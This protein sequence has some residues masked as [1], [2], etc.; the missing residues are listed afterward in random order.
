MLNNLINQIFL[1]GYSLNVFGT[2]FDALSSKYAIITYVV[3]ILVI[4]I[5]LVIFIYRLLQP[6]VV[7]RL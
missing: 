6:E 3:I 4:M 7:R 2:I 1:Q 5:L